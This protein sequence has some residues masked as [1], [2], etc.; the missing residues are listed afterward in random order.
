MFSNPI[1]S[2]NRLLLL[3]EA[4]MSPSL[5]ALPSELVS[6][7][8]A[9]IASKP[10]LGNLAQCSHRLYRCSLPHLYRHITIHEEAK[11][12]DEQ[13]GQLRKLASLLLQRPD[14]AELVQHFELHVLKPSWMS[15]EPEHFVYSIADEQSRMAEESQNYEQYGSPKRVTAS[16]LSKEQKLSCLAQF[17]DTHTCHHDLI[18]PMLLPVLLK[19]E[20]VELDFEIDAETYFYEKC[21]KRTIRRWR[22]SNTH[23][24]VNTHWPVIYGP[25]LESLTFFVHSRN[26]FKVRRAS[27]T[28]SLHELPAIQ[29]VSGAFAN[30]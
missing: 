30:R 19:V 21:E 20:K 10:A 9:N 27:W 5:T 13:L 4:T 12:G 8:M 2:C 25:K 11:S 3:W 17:S 15:E 7:I 18:L 16:S 26:R 22:P 28:A 6:S 29:H 1:Q 24:P 23:Q 14:L